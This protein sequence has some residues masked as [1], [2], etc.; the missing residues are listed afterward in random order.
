MKVLE[1]HLELYSPALC[2]WFFCE[3]SWSTQVLKS[4]PV[5][6][7]FVLSTGFISVYCVATGIILGLSTDS[8]AVKVPTDCP[9]QGY[10]G[11]LHS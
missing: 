6:A 10:Y 4:F 2:I 8:C 3:N 5:I 1:G 7:S 11:Y 9:K